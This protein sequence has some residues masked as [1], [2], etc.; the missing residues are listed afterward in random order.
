ME[1]FAVEFKKA[2]SDA[3]TA[4]SMDQKPTGGS[5]R[6]TQRETSYSS[7]G[8]FSLKD[9]HLTSDMRSH[10]EGKYLFSRVVSSERLTRLQREMR[11][12]EEEYRRA[13]RECAGEDG[14][15]DPAELVDVLRSLGAHVTERIARN[16]LGQVLCMQKRCAIAWYHT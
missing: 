14:Q 9:G 8:S 7:T 11:R 16:I 2:Q 12:T 15:M 13:F 5:T 6:Q 4:D 1:D 3:G 10:A